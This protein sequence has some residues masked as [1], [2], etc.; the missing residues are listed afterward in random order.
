MKNFNKL[1]LL[2]VSLV[3]TT[4]IIAQTI[5]MPKW[6]LNGKEIDFTTTNI[7]VNNLNSSLTGACGATN[8]Y[9]DQ[10]HT[11]LFH[12][13]DTKLYAS[14]GSFAGDLYTD[15]DNAP[16]EMGAEIIV[17]PA[18]PTNNCLYYVIYPI[19]EHNADNTHSWKVCYNLVCWYGPTIVESGV[20]CRESGIT[21]G[22]IAISDFINDNGSVYH[23]LQAVG[24][25]PLTNLMPNLYINGELRLRVQT[26]LPNMNNYEFCELDMSKDGRVIAAAHLNNDRSNMN[27]IYPYNITIWCVDDTGMPVVI[28]T[29]DIG[30]PGDL[31]EQFTGV[32]VYQDPN[33]PNVKGIFSSRV[34]GSKYVSLISGTTYYGTNPVASTN[35]FS[36]SQLEF[37]RRGYLASTD[38]S[39]LLQEINP[40]GGAY[41]NHNIGTHNAV[42]NNF[43][44]NSNSHAPIVYTLPDQVDQANYDSY[45]IGTEYN[46][47]EA[48]HVSV[49][50]TP[51]SGV[52]YNY[53]TG[54]V[55][56][57]GNSVNW[58]QTSNPFTSGGH[59][60]TDIYLKGSLKID[61]GK[62]LS[63]YG[64]TIILS[65]TNT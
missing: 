56:I 58:T 31:T 60:I 26:V 41:Q 52:A 29:K 3:I 39:N 11:L 13:I 62:K 30:T 65:L 23:K 28:Y 48:A 61:P 64:L 16:D 14:D 43:I 8:G 53:E 47:C 44:Y 24:R 34:G 57:S 9:Y 45:T 5:Q 18:E 17:V 7:T 63:I 15:I 46:C 33:N 22:G 49:Y 55:T 51:M 38:N 25:G 2:V 10:N 27:D 21:H 37:D 50:K 20:L 40:I 19:Q 42:R 6:P 12:I 32:E 4:N 35:F 59:A 1:L 36:N 54:D